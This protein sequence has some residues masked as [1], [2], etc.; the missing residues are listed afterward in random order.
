MNLPC[1]ERDTS[2]YCVKTTEVVYQHCISPLIIQ[3]VRKMA[4]SINT[5][6]IYSIFNDYVFIMYRF[7]LETIN[8][9]KPKIYFDYF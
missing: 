7:I 3:I 4:V 1:P 8:K 6:N 9:I 2:L 5:S